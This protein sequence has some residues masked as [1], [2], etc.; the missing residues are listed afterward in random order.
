LHGGLSTGPKTIEGIGRIRAANTRHGRWS[1]EGLAVERARRRWFADGYRSARAFE[2][3]TIKG[4][5][6]RRYLESLLRAEEAQGAALPQFEAW[7]R[8]ARQAVAARVGERLRTKGF[9]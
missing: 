8:E 1:A 6:G 2:G 7:R 9:L 4:V 3:G 5:N